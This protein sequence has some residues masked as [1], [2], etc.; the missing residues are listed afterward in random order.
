MIILFPSWPTRCLQVWNKNQFKELF[1]CS[2]YFSYL[3]SISS[4]QARL[5]LTR[6]DNWST[7]GSTRDSHFS[8]LPLPSIWNDSYRAKRMENP[9]H[10][11]RSGKERIGKILQSLL[12]VNRNNYLLIDHLHALRDLCRSLSRSYCV[13]KWKPCLDDSILN[14]LY[15]RISGKFKSRFVKKKRFRSSSIWYI[16]YENQSKKFRFSMEYPD[17]EESK[18]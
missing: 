13:S 15:T 2:L 3:S 5:F 18:L 9:L 10:H 11:H 4:L 6:D 7:Y 17:S 1:N 14:L 8:L 12:L 16:S